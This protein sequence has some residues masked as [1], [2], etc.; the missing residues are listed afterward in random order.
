MVYRCLG[1]CRETASEV[2]FFAPTDWG[3]TPA[4]KR[5]ERKHRVITVG[6]G[7]SGLAALMRMRESGISV[8]LREARDRAGARIW[9]GTLDEAEV[10]WGGEW[11]GSGQPR[12]CALVEQPGVR[13]FPTY[14]EGNEVIE[15]GER[16]STYTRLISMLAP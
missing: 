7:L 13:T 6:A 2:P 16:I 8:R 12:V 4:H 3:A 1:G 9:S 14:D 11:I 15:V 5:S 10:D